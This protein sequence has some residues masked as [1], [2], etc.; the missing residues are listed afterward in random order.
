MD[1]WT[2]AQVKRMK[3]GGNEKCR[4]FFEASEDY[5]KNMSIPDKVRAH[6]LQIKSYSVEIRIQKLT[7]SLVQFSF[8][9]SIQGETLSR[10]RRNRLD[11]FTK[12]STPNERFKK[13]SNNEFFSK[14]IASST[15]FLLGLQ[16]IF[17]YPFTKSWST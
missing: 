1:K 17:L 6:S 12:T 14:F 10:S 4:A 2:E 9:F 16:W 15:S 7:L 5:S 3:A 13:T 11:P 8:R